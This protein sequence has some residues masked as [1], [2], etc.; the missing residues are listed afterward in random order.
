MLEESIATRS[1]EPVSLHP[2][3]DPTLCAGCAACTDVCPE[4]GILRIVDHKAVLVSPTQCLGHGECE[5]ACPTE[6][7]TLVFG[8]KSRG[9]DIP[10]VTSDYE[11]NISG[12]YVAGELGGMGL[13]RNAIKQGHIA[14]AHALNGQVA[15]NDKVD[16]DLLVIGA[17]P[18]GLAAALTAISE[19]RSYICID[20]NSFGGT[21]TNYPRQKLVMSHPAY[22]PIVGTMKFKRNT[23][24]KEE[25]LEFW[26]DVRRKTQL[27]VQEKTRFESLKKVADAFDVMTSHGTIRARK[28]IL[29]LGVRGS[30][31]RLGLLNEDLPKVTH[32]LIDPEQYRRQRIAIVGGGNS[33]VEAACTLAQSRLRNEVTLFVRGQ[34]L[35]RCNEENK[36]QIQKLAS[37]NALQIWFKSNVVEIQKD[38]LVV[39]RDGVQKTIENELLFIFAGVEKPH[40]FLMSVGIEI[41]KKFGEALKSRNEYTS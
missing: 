30:P 7:I 21:V 25:L 5:R 2:Q 11:T 36:M 26:H 20:Q 31:R 1:H 6:A 35:D 34:A 39:K 9:M 33:A 38:Q 22:L 15:G 27:K 40:K 13:I 10:R 19:K 14:A 4:G 41:D 37:D 3:V 17:G 12:L 28:V 8:T 29:C 23:V 32:D 24:S 18:A 16:T